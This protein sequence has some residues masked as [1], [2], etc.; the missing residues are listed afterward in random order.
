MMASMA[1]FTF[2]D[3]CIKLTEGAVP[4]FQLLFLRGVLTTLLVFCLA[5]YL[6][7]I[8]LGISRRDWGLIALR[9]GAEIA[10]AYFFLTALFNMPLANVTAIL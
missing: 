8:H 9:S 4:L 6:G 3:A 10:A 1:A 5:R 7:T 2:N